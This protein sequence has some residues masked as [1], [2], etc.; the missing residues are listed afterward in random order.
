MIAKELDYKGQ[1]GLSNK[2][3]Y[4][5]QSALSQHYKGKPFSDW[6]IEKGLIEFSHKK[7]REIFYKSNPKFLVEIYK[8]I[9]GERV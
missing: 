7:S 6:L 3:G 8:K 1:S 9:F 2:C 5:N 4:I